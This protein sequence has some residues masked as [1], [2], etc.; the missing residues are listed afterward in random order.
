MIF[1]ITGILFVFRFLQARFRFKL[2]VVGCTPLDSARLHTISPE[3]TLI[4]ATKCHE[5]ERFQNFLPNFL[6]RLVMAVTVVNGC[7][8]CNDH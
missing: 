1:G 2:N 3:L 4:D 7:N 5:L 6:Q 8:G